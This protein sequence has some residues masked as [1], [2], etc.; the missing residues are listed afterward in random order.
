VVVK[1]GMAAPQ[2]VQR[3]VDAIEQRCPRFFQPG[4]I[5]LS[6]VEGGWLRVYPQSD[7][8]L[9]VLDDGQIF[10]KYMRALNPELIGTTGQVVQET[11]KMDCTA[12]RGRS[13]LPWEHEI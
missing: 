7:T 10:Y 8:R 3:A 13:G 9:Y 5:A 1:P 4:Q 11:F 2:A 6:R 12:I